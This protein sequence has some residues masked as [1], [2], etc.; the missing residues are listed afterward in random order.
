MENLQFQKIFFLKDKKNFYITN[1][2]SLKTTH[3]LRSRVNCILTTSKTINDDNPKFNCRI[4]GLEN[5]SPLL[6]Y[7]IK[8]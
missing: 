8:N 6:L 7:L 2:F 5:K 3:I 4:D 1:R